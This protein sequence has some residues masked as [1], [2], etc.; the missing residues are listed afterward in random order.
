MPPVTDP[1]PAE[2]NVKDFSRQYLKEGMW[3]GKIKPSEC[4]ESLSN[5]AHGNQILQ[6][7]GEKKETRIKPYQPVTDRVIF[8][9]KGQLSI[10]RT[11]DIAPTT[12]TSFYPN[13]DL[14]IVQKINST[15][16]NNYY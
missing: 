3:P 11:I 2:K 6:A 4:R 9:S 10:S 12:A 14:N 16:D 8:H 7:S 15:L 5:L 13:I 1:K